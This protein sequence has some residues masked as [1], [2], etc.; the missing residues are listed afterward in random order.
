MKYHELL[1]RYIEESKLSLGELVLRLKNH[2]I[3]ITKSYISKLKNGNKPPAS[4]DITRA[5][6]EAAGGDPDALVMAAYIDKAPTEVRE[7]LREAERYRFV[8]NLIRKLIEFIEYYYAHQEVQEDLLK[9]IQGIGFE[10]RET[11]HH[12]YPFDKLEDDPEF[13]LQLIGS[14]RSQFFPQ[15]PSVT[16]G[17]ETINFTRYIN[18]KGTARRRFPRPED[19]KEASRNDG[20]DFDRDIDVTQRML[21]ATTDLLKET[22]DYIDFLEHVDVDVE[23]VEDILKDV[24]YIKRYMSKLHKNIDGLQATLKEVTRSKEPASSVNK[25]RTRT[26]GVVSEESGEYLSQAAYNGKPKQLTD[27][28]RQEFEAKRRLFEEFNGK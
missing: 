11:Y 28:E 18:E 4:E 5:L 10:L 15:T 25:V 13:A 24:I 23:F 17:T 22:D 16:M 21:N 19:D 8:F 26:F 1:S 20:K 7:A 6:A 27:Q 3:E 14:L 2:D 12:S 9:E